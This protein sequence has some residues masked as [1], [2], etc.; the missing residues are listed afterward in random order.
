MPTLPSKAVYVATKPPSGDS[1]TRGSSQPPGHSQAC[2]ASSS[3]KSTG[4]GS[5]A[6]VSP[7]SLTA[8]P[9]R[10]VPATATDRVLPPEE[11]VDPSLVDDGTRV[12]GILRGPGH[13]DAGDGAG[14]AGVGQV[15]QDLL[16]D[17]GER[18]EVPAVG[19]AVASRA[20]TAALA[21]TER[22]RSMIPK[23]TS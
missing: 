6:N 7:S 13:V 1:T 16:A 4:S 21:R 12:E 10:E 8:R 18:P 2:H 3:G 17:R 11:H 5:T 22:S 15:G 23:E 20:R 19:H 9:I 14:E